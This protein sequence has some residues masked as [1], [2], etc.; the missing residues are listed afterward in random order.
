MTKR[1][2]KI[3]DSF[4][5]SRM[6]ICLLLLSVFLP[7]ARTHASGA[8]DSV[9]FHAELDTVGSLRAGQVVQLTYA[10]VNSQFDTAFYPVFNDSIEVLNGPKPHKRESYAIINGEE[11]KSRETGFYLSYPK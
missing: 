10:L 3:K 5:R 7:I 11:R 6:F 1:T 9:Y 4:I 2:S 8:A